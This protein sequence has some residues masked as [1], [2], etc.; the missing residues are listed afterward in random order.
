M[1]QFIL[2]AHVHPLRLHACLVIQANKQDDN[3]KRFP[4]ICGVLELLK[5]T[6]PISDFIEAVKWIVGASDLPILLIKA[7]LMVSAYMKRRKSSGTDGIFNPEFYD[8]PYLKEY[9]YDSR[10]GM[11]LLKGEFQRTF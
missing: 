5:P 3:D 6:L 1:S 8:I 2:P 4:A 11:V 10:N 9:L 7:M